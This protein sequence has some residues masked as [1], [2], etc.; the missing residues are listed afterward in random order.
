MASAKVMRARTVFFL[1]LIFS[2]GIISC[3]G[4]RTFA[5]YKIDAIDVVGDNRIENLAVL[6][7]YGVI[8]TGGRLDN[9]ISRRSVL[10][11][12]DQVENVPNA[13]KST[14]DFRPTAPGHSPGAGH[15]HG[16]SSVDPN[17]K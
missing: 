10:D 11:N 3:Q 5:K 4:I 1:V 13:I 7:K 17:P 2:C 9:I 8:G 6:G 16:P 14:D 12:G 15:S